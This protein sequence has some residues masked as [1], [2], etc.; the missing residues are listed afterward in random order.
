MFV[1]QVFEEYPKLDAQI[2]WNCN[3][4]GFLTDPLKGKVICDK[5]FRN[6]LHI[7]F[8][9]IIHITVDKDSIVTCECRANHS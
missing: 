8:A 1:W 9:F 7:Y 4:S 6:T 3:E 2:I 5:V